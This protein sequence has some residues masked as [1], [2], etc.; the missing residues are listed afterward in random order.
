MLID[1]HCHILPGI[2]DG[3]LDIEDSVGMAL[4]A[5]ADGIQVVCATPHVRHDHDVV[6]H[7]LPART[8][9]L[10]AR[11]RERGLGVR[12]A[13]GAEV[14]ETALDGLDEDELRLASLCGTGR[15]VLLE[16]APGP[17]S[18]S[19]TH[20]VDR[21]RERGARPVIAHPERHAAED[22][23]ER[24]HALIERGALVQVTAALFEDE[25]AGPVLL[26]LFDRGLAHLLGSDAHSSHAGRPVALSLALEKLAT[27]PRLSPHLDWV[28]HEAPAAILRGEE[29][30]PPF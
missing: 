21:L 26:G 4:Q 14:A 23:E 17:L 12:V 20:A 3:A 7:E 10:N 19:L 15:W 11:L 18:D 28:A 9:Q 29:V 13:Q 5:E 27:S 22:L 6:V 8:E 25:G 2:D 30:E 1:L 16:P 24:L